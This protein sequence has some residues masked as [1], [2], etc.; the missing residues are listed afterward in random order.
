MPLP[1]LPASVDAADGFSPAPSAVHSFVSTEQFEVPEELLNQIA[2]LRLNTAFE[3]DRTA[4]AHTLEAL[5]QF[6]LK[7]RGGVR[8]T[9]RALC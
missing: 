1:K 5:L 8:S 2:T 6:T 9:S 3:R 7:Q 4:M